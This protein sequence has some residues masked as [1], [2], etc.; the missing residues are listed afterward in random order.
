MERGSPQNE[1]PLRNKV[2]T[3]STDGVDDC[4]KK[5]QGIHPLLLILQSQ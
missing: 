4:F 5:M 2:D 1:C 3:A